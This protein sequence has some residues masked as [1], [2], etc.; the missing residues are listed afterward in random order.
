MSE[1]RSER[2]TF[3]NC[4]D[5]SPSQTIRIAEASN[6]RKTNRSSGRKWRR[7][8]YF[9]MTPENRHSTAA[10]AASRQPFRWPGDAIT[11]TSIRCGLE[12]FTWIFGRELGDANM[13]LRN[14]CF[15]YFIFHMPYGM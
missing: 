13:Y 1:R 12:L 6:V 7:S 5:L 2:R 15:P 9:V 8:R 14:D 10:E 4:G 3:N 11:F